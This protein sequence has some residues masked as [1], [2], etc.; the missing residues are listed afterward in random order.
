MIPHRVAQ[1]ALAT[2]IVIAFLSCVESLVESGWSFY[3]FGFIAL[4]LTG[5]FLATVLTRRAWVGWFLILSTVTWMPPVGAFSRIGLS[6]YLVLMVLGVLAINVLGGNFPRVGFTKPGRLVLFALVLMAAR[7]AYERPGFAQLGGATGGGGFA[8]SYICALIGFVVFSRRADTEQN[9]RA[10]MRLVLWLTLPALPLQWVAAWSSG[11]VML[12]WYRMLFIS[13]LWLFSACFLAYVLARSSVRAGLGIYFL[14]WL[15]ILLPLAVSLLSPH[16]SRPLMAASVAVAVAYVS[17]ARRV[18]WKLLIAGGL[19][20]LMF[21][22][23]V[24]SE[25]LPEPVR[26]SVSTMSATDERSRLSS[27]EW[28]WNSPWRGGLYRMALGEISQRPLLG[29]GVAFSTYDMI[30]RI[31]GPYGHLARIGSWHNIGLTLAVSFGLPVAL[32]FL[33]G[34]FWLTARFVVTLRR[35]PPGE[36]KSLMAG[37]LGYSACCWAQGLM[38]GGVGDIYI[39]A[40]LLGIM[41]GYL[42]KEEHGTA[43]AGRARGRN[44]EVV[45]EHA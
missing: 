9:P 19:A 11:E 21:A 34:A 40:V 32:L 43:G 33:T 26:R 39:L 3:S 4:I 23:L 42:L 5:A 31:D 36:E 45:G 18:Y 30:A 1:I 28:G 16:R 12:P 35:S 38:N 14:A 29:S 44:K 15:A 13:P 27:E 8:L 2:G 7:V 41:N 17:H 20:V 22:L 6:Q 24:P 37:L 25:V 10:S